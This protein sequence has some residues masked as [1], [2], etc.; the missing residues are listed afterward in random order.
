MC[1]F[2]SYMGA[3]VTV[4]SLLVDPVYSLLTQ[5]RTPR[6]QRHGKG[7]PDG[8]GVGWYES[9]QSGTPLR[10]RSAVPMW[11]DEA[12]LAHSGYIRSSTIL[13]HIRSATPGS[14]VNEV[15]TH[16]FA[17]DHWLFAHNGSVANF[18]G[19]VGAQL[20]NTISARRLQAVEGTTDSEVL[21]AL[22]LDLLD[23][24][25]EP[26][27]A[28][29]GVIEAVCAIDTGQAHRLN[30]V[31]TDGKRLA[32]TSYGDTLFMLD[33]DGFAPKGVVIASEPCDDNPAWQ[34]VPDESVVEATTSGGVVTSPTLSR[35]TA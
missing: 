7:N 23:T 4:E 6:M 15:N 29:R 17:S 9:G 19:K 31:L 8:Y 14:A 33:H 1:R 35:S 27:E 11:A 24:G 34:A 16:P 2:L 26:G 12:F 10:H 28:L 25:V 18:A 32:A 30:L 22:A 5:A 13:G 20:R 3:P 21:F